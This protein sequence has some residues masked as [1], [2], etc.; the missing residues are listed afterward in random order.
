MPV[1]T[2]YKSESIE[3]VANTN[4]MRQMSTLKKK[5]DANHVDL[6]QVSISGGGHEIMDISKMSE[7]MPQVIRV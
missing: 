1:F 7:Q 3:V 2:Q 4:A 6:D 5:D